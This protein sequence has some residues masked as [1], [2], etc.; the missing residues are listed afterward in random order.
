MVTDVQITTGSPTVVVTLAKAKKHLRIEDSFAEEDD[1]IQDYIDAAVT[2]AENYIG[3]HIVD[4]NMII[5]MTGFDNPLI[6]EAFPVKSVTSVKYFT[7]GNDDEQTMSSD[8]YILNAEHK[9]RY[10]IR[11]KNNLP[12]LQNRVDAVTVTISLGMTTI[13][14]PIVSAVL[15]MISDLYERREDR[16]EVVSTAAMSLLRPYKKF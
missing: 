5:K 12:V 8:D 1:L 10:A 9:K 4:K 7:A 15:L 14:K 13:E 11:F 16:S 6:F 3:G 2:N